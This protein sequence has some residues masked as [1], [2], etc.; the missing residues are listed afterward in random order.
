MNW[1]VTQS[2]QWQFNLKANHQV[3]KQ[4]TQDNLQN[5]E[6]YV[7]I[8]KTPYQNLRLDK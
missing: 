1:M 8:I 7:G 3:T 2:L 4:E 6:E 5:G